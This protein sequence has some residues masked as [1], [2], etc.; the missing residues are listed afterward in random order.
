LFGRAIG[1]LFII[2]FIFFIITKRVGGKLLFKCSVLLLMGA[3]QGFIG[4]YMV[5]SGLVNKPHV[6]HLRLALHLSTALLA[7]SYCL[8][9]AF[10][11]RPSN[12]K[13]TLDPKVKSIAVILLVLL[14]VQIIYGAFVSGL[15]AGYIY[16]T[17]PMMGGNWIPYDMLRMDPELLN[18]INNGSS[19]QFVHR[20]IG[21]LILLS[22]FFLLAAAY[23]KHK[24]VT[25]NVAT[26]VA[27]LIIAQFLFGVI[28]LLGRVPLIP[29]LMHQ[30]LAFI[31][32]G[33]TL[34]LYR[35]H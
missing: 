11:L 33:S 9:I 27:I 28:T 2:P 32:F 10:D 25:F 23:K 18:F 24:K 15:K 35:L 6:D 22:S 1:L 13:R 21:S 29:A 17:I 26:F 16:N 12:V 31:L 14:S 7:F 19:V 20:F 5:K 4:W 8:W 3:A 34:I 30:S